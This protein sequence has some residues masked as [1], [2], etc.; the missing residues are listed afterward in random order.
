MRT[1]RPR[2]Q[3]PVAPAGERDQEGAPAVFA[4]GVDVQR[5][6]AVGD[7]G[8]LKLFGAGVV[9]RFEVAQEAPGEFAD[10]AG[11][12]PDAVLLEQGR[13]DL[14]A[15]AVM[16]EAKQANLDQDVVA[17]D[18]VRG[19]EA[20]KQPRPFCNQLAGRPATTRD[21]RVHGLTDLEWA[22]FDGHARAAERLLH[23]HGAAAERAWSGRFIRRNEE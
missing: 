17:D 23:A 8:C 10:L 22:V 13:T 3:D 19:D 14:V 11:G 6:A 21:T 5:P 9:E 7:E 1:L 20:S 15:L 16:N 2:P 12:E 18:A 4:G